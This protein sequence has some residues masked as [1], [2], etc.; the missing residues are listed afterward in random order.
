[1]QRQ[2]HCDVGALARDFGESLGDARKTPAPI[3]TSMRGRDD[4]RTV[5]LHQLN[6]AWVV[7]RVVFVC[8]PLQGIDSG[9]AGY[10]DASRGHVF[11]HEVAEVIGGRCEVEAGNAGDQLAVQF[12]R[13]R[14]ESVVGSQ[15]GLHVNHWQPDLDRRERTGH[16]GGGVAV[17]EDHCGSGDFP[18]RVSCAQ[19]RNDVFNAVHNRDHQ[20]VKRAGFRAHIEVNVGLNLGH[21][22]HGRNEVAVLAGKDH[23]GFEQ[24]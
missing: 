4:H 23:E 15:P 24:Q 21:L 1:M 13:E 9:V 19:V 11:L 18:L 6:E 14:R 2:H 16:R 12:F 3:F 20:A 10:E 8:C 22:E 7:E 17:H 5:S